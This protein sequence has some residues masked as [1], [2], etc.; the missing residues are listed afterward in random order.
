MNIFQGRTLKQMKEDYLELLKTLEENFCLSKSSITIGTIPPLANISF[1]MHY[2]EF[3]T[4]VCFNNWLRY[5][6][7]NRYDEIGQRKFSY[8]FIDFHKELL[9]DIEEV[10]YDYFQK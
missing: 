2:E 4:L 9:T 8:K 7:D 10:N 1:R 6:I 5:L 3:S